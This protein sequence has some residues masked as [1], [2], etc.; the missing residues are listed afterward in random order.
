MGAFATPSTPDIVNQYKALAIVFGIF[1]VMPGLLFFGLR[2]L[3]RRWLRSRATTETASECSSSK[4]FAQMS[5]STRTYIAMAI[6]VSSAVAGVVAIDRGW[7]SA[8]GIAFNVSCPWILSGGWLAGDFTR[9]GLRRLNKPM[10]TIFEAAK[11]RKLRK[12]EPPSIARVMNSGGGIMV[13]VG[14]VGWFF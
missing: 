13:L 10:S 4:R 8:S 5:P 7:G 1:I 11:Q 14:I 9:E 2:W 6:C 3:A 12:P